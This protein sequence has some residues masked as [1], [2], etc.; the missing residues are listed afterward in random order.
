[1]RSGNSSTNFYKK[2]SILTASTTISLSK[3]QLGETCRA[4]VFNGG[5]V[6][7]Q[8]TLSLHLVEQLNPPGM[9]KLAAER[10]RWRMG[11]GV[12]VNMKIGLL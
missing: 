7:F 1:M 6:F 4:R 5:F 10:R 11:Y 8:R 9:T 2:N 3:H 12:R